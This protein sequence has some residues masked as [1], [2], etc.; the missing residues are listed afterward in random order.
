MYLHCV[1]SF[2]WCAYQ[3]LSVIVDSDPNT[4]AC[5]RA[6][7]NIGGTTTP[8]RSW[9]IYVTQYACGDYDISGWPGC[10]QYYTATSDTIQKWVICTMEIKTWTFF[11]LQRMKRI[12]LNSAILLQ[13]FCL[14][15]VL[16]H[17]N[18][19]SAKIPNDYLLWFLHFMLILINACS[20]FA[21]LFQGKCR[22]S[23]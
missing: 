4:G 17:Q 3:L 20:G 23:D 12:E 6:V 2:S 16:R 8:S 10:L 21:K 1:R 5:H 9:D 14:L 7:F 11:N 15:I 19:R 13:C 18:I 22:Q